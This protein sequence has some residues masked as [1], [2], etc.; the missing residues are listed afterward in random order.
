MKK[1]YSLL[2]IA[3][4]AVMAFTLFAA[5]DDPTDPNDPN[6]GEKQ[7]IQVEGKVFAYDRTEASVIPGKEAA[8]E[9]YIAEMGNPEIAT[10]D[11]FLK[12]MAA[13]YDESFAG[14]KFVFY[15][16]VVYMPD[17]FEFTQDGETVSIEGFEAGESIESYK[18]RVQ[19]EEFVIEFTTGEDE[20]LV[21]L[22]FIFA[23][24]RDAAETDVPVLG[25][26]R[27]SYQL[28]SV[29]LT[30]LSQFGREELIRQYKLEFGDA[31][32]ATD[33]E[34]IEFFE[35]MYAGMF[36][37]DYAYVTATDGMMF[38][39]DSSNEGY[40]YLQY[41]QDGASIEMSDPDALSGEPLF[42]ATTRGNK[43]YVEMDMNLRDG[44]RDAVFT[45]EYTLCDFIDPPGATFE[46]TKP[47]LEPTAAI[48]GDMTSSEMLQAALDNYY[49][50]DFVLQKKNGSIE[51]SVIGLSVEQLVESV[52]IREGAA[53]GDYSIYVR[54]QS[55][56]HDGDGLIQKLIDLRY[57]D[58]IDYIKSGSAEEV[59]HRIAAR[60]NY[61][62]E[63]IYDKHDDLYDWW[64]GWTEGESYAS[65]TKYN[66]LNHFVAQNAFDPT[67]IL[68]YDLS[69]Q[70]ITTM[71]DPVYHADRGTYTFDVALSAEAAA[72]YAEWWRAV[73][74][75]NDHNAE[76]EFTSVTLKFE[77]WDNGF[78]KSVTAQD[79][80]YIKMSGIINCNAVFET[81]TNFYFECDNLPPAF[82][83]AFDT[84]RLGEVKE[85]Y[86]TVGGTEVPDVDA[87]DVNGKTF[88]FDHV[89]IEGGEKYEELT[90]E[91]VEE[92]LKFGNDEY[93]NVWLSF[94][95]GVMSCNY[96]VFAGSY[97]QNGNT[98]T[99]TNEDFQD[100][101]ATIED[102]KLYMRLDDGSMD[103]V[104]IYMVMLLVDEGIS[105]DYS[106]ADKTFTIVSC[107]I[108]YVTPEQEQALME[109]EGWTVE[110]YLAR[111]EEDFLGAELSFASDGSVTA[112]GDTGTYTYMQD[113]NLTIEFPNAGLSMDGDVRIDGEMK[114]RFRLDL[115]IQ[116]FVT[117]QAGR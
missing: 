106:V 63:T 14:E 99:Y 13:G 113:G 79:N 65:P 97:T 39:I 34:I 49:G 76:I 12:I 48:N 58:E 75:A 11:D 19:G 115:D 50:A 88:L 83:D 105:A 61:E 112:F 33:E 110:D 21:V 62:V 114:L 100:Q 30:E 47:D 35:Q 94:K 69:Q 10:V 25:I 78:L 86:D 87:F 91:S 95:D 37:Q 46:P 107:D 31:T 26:D 5:C 42:S 98:L 56:T 104:K 93:Y 84:S 9:A 52:T 70:N 111:V 16:G 57:W 17:A 18:F 45:L 28:D 60:D 8:L 92:A 66:S 90:G 71:T 24:D 44:A 72:N 15:Q 80:F 2:V 51:T 36:S 81:K 77:I 109:E 4:V 6:D 27:N 101:I 64:L 117:A 73:L 108:P 102:G 96:D 23:Y 3:L 41:V 32:D 29:E 1:F 59:Y 68:M 67:S 7:P 116:I 74:A 54:N 43:L 55:V 85:Y 20:A 38:L 82:D 53:D 103:G 40:V 89:E 22:K